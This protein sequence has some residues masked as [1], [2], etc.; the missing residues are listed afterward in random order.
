MTA[1]LEHPPSIP[2]RALVWL[3]LSVLAALVTYVSFRG[4]LTPELLLNFANWFYC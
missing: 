4:Y 3:A 1:D 2:R